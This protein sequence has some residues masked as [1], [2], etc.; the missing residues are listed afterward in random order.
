M[1]DRLDCAIAAVLIAATLLDFVAVVIALA[2]R[3]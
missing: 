1:N 2:H 3:V